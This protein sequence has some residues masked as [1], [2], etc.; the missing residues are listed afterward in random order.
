MGLRVVA[1]GVR[2]VLA[3][4]VADVDRVGLEHGGRRGL[5]QLELLRIPDKHV[6][7]REL[8]P[9]FERFLLE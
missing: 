5:D 7:D 6:F 4:R 9:D 1:R 3:E 2:W 8:R